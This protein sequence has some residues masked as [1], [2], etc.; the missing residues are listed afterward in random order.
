[1]L[2]GALAGRPCFYLYQAPPVP[3]PLIWHHYRLCIGFE[4]ALI[5]ESAAPQPLVPSWHNG[6]FWLGDAIPGTLSLR[7]FL[8]QCP[9]T[10]PFY[11]L[12]KSTK[13]HREQL[14]SQSVANLRKG[15]VVQETRPNK[16]SLVVF[17]LSPSSLCL[18]VSL[19]L[20]A[21][22]RY[23]SILQL[24]E[25]RGWITRSNARKG[26]INLYFFTPGCLFFHQDISA[27]HNGLVLS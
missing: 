2:V 27:D 19:S 18:S 24:T 20:L 25:T 15:L 23:I 26:L 14:I 5:L 11:C 9:P 4:T 1:M 6:A 21:R 12:V 8:P 3:D 16:R 7:G 13:L 17:L 10:D 22:F